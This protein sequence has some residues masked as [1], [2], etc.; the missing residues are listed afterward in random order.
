MVYMDGLNN[1]QAHNDP[2]LDALVRASRVFIAVVAKSVADIEDLVTAPQWRIL[3][4]IATRGPQ[5]HRA[6]AA[7]LRVHPSNATRTVNK[8]QTAGLVRRE[9][10]PHDRR[11][12]RLQLT[13]E[14]QSL[15]NRV[16][17]NRRRALNDV[18]SRMGAGDRLALEK[19][20][21]AFAEAAGEST[22]EATGAALG[23]G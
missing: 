11:F 4:L 6:V 2:S 18:V 9:E 17:S 13:D 8:L 12:L 19:A 20:M 16:M 1:D 7:D 10:D 22:S 23:L 3:I 15:V 5:T 14:G 21:L